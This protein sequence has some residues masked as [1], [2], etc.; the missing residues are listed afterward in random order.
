M[1]AATVKGIRPWTRLNHMEQTMRPQ[2]VVAQGA[3]KRR[4]AFALLILNVNTQIKIC[5]VN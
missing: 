5:K 4:A 1:S 2:R 3:Q